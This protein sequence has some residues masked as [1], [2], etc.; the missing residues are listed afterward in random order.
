MHKGEEE[1]WREREIR[2]QKEENRRGRGILEKRVFSLLLFL[3]NFFW[4]AIEVLII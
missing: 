2:T 3:F 4:W 1:N